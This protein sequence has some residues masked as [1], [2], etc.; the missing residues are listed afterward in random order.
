[1]AEHPSDRTSPRTHDQRH[2][3]RAVATIDDETFLICDACGREVTM[4]RESAR[5][6]VLK[7]GDNAVPHQSFLTT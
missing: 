5:Y 3:L 1:M 7:A 6:L 2:T 4:F